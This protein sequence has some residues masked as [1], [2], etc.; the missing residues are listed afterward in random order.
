MKRLWVL[1]ALV[2]LPVIL[3]S[4]ITAPT[5]VFIETPKE[6][7]AQ[8]SSDSTIMHVYLAGVVDTFQ[9]VELTGVVIDSI[10]DRGATAAIVDLTYVAGNRKYTQRDTLRHDSQHIVPYED[11]LGINDS[12]FYF[13]MGPNTTA[14]GE[15]FTITIR[16]ALVARVS[17][18]G[19]TLT[20][21]PDAAFTFGVDSLNTY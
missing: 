4:Q 10:K 2:I 9:V 1:L 5:P 14:D 13:T 11:R 18:L 16:N 3:L 12:V 20:V 21:K 19:D 8:S 15:T 17:L 6:F 7:K